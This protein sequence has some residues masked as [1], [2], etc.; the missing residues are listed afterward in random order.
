MIVTA[1]LTLWSHFVILLL[2]VPMSKCIR[3]T[4]SYAHINNLLFPFTLTFRT[5]KSSYSFIK[6]LSHYRISHYLSSW[7]LVLHFSYF[8]SLAS[9]FSPFVCLCDGNWPNGAHYFLTS[10]NFLVQ[11]VNASVTSM[12]IFILLLVF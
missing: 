12:E 1:D 8:S 11:I 5:N 4:H 10:H 6:V 3:N 7:H 2:A 9:I